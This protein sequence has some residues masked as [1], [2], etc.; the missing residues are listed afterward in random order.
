M[1]IFLLLAVTTETSPAVQIAAPPNLI[2]GLSSPPSRTGTRRFIHI[3]MRG[4]LYSEMLLP[5][6]MC[7]PDGVGEGAVCTPRWPVICNSAMSTERAVSMTRPFTFR[8][9]PS[10]LLKGSL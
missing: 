2:P 10:S 8:D 4:P 7:V 5:I 1:I 6:M 9:T 3:Y